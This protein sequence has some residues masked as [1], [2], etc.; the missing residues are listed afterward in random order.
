MIPSRWRLSAPTPSPS[1]RPCPVSPRRRRRSPEPLPLL[2][3]DRRRCPGG[4]DHGWCG[5]RPDKEDDFS[6]YYSRW[7]FR[8]CN[9][10]SPGNLRRT[11]DLPSAAPAPPPRCRSPSRGPRRRTEPGGRCSACCRERRSGS[12]EGSWKPSFT[13][14]SR[15]MQ[16][17][18]H[19]P[20]FSPPRLSQRLNLGRWGN[21][22][23]FP[24]RNE[25]QVLF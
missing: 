14:R 22:V 21:T 1:W 18:S 7:L 8:N 4:D 24:L 3:L 9:N 12:G 25:K 15:L 13:F 5:G 11:L 20:Y 16:L 19:A 17:P 6:S 10:T 2:P 23:R